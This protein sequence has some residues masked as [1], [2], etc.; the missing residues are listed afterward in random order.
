MKS[1]VKLGLGCQTD[2]WVLS[3][4]V[5]YVFPVSQ[6]QEEEEQQQEPLPQKKST[7]PVG[8]ALQVWNLAHKY[9]N[10]N[11]KAIVHVTFLQV[12]N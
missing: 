4:E 9:Q 2:V 11:Q 6:E 10:N 7:V 5:D 8:S 12:T 3:L 1:E